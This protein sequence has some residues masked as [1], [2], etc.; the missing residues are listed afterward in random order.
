LKDDHKDVPRTISN[1][2]GRR[3]ALCWGAEHDLQAFAR[4]SEVLDARRREDVGN[5]WR[6]DKVLEGSEGL[7]WVREQLRAYD[8]A[9]VDW[10]TV[11]CGRTLGLLPFICM[12]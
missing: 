9:K 3:P 1:R 4:S 11:R 12:I 10:I 2:L 7:R 6:M 5:L 8:W